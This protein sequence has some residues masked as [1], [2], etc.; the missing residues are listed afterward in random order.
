MVEPREIRRSRSRGRARRSVQ[1]WRKNKLLFQSKVARRNSEQ[2]VD[3]QDA[4]ADHDTRTRLLAA[5][6]RLFAQRG[7][8]QTSTSAISR[9]ARTSESQLIRHFE[10]KRGLLAAIFDDGWRLLNREAQVSVA[11]TDN[12]GDATDAVLRSVIA[13]FERD[14][15]LACVLLLE[16]RRIHAGEP[17]VVLS[18][19]YLEFVDFLERLIRQAQPK[20]VRSST[21]GRAAISSALIGAA[22]GMIRDRLIAVRSGRKPPFPLKDVQLVFRHLLRALLS[23]PKAAGRPKRKSTR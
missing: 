20:S 3:T 14:P 9:E 18:R 15:E 16:G 11:A 4:H 10:G 2:R 17:G 6:K 7:Y 22:E 5:G 21:F 19:G 12:A 23:Q 8:E 13:V 1:Q